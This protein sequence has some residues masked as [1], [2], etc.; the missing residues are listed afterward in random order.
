MAVALI[1]A[2]GFDPAEVDGQAVYTARISFEKKREALYKT[3]QD[4][5]DAALALQTSFHYEGCNFDSAPEAEFLNW[6]LSLLQ[7]EAPR[8]RPRAARPSP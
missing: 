4:T 5:A 1:K 2:E 7:T 3:A 6:C 8:K